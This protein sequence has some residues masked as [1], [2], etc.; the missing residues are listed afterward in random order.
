[1]RWR[2][3][4]ADASLEA[5]LGL[6]TRVDWLKKAREPNLGKYWGDSV[7]RALAASGQP[8]AAEDDEAGDSGGGGTTQQSTNGSGHEPSSF[9]SN[10]LVPEVPETVIG[11]P[12]PATNIH[13]PMPAR[14]HV[15]ASSPT[16]R[17]R[18]LAEAFDRSNS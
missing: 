5:V 12:F 14:K 10:K 17:P 3:E 15:E 2:D 13:K 18:S 9:C 1:M 8:K 11:T 16:V 4:L 6:M 7:E